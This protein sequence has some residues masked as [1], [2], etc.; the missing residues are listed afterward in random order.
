MSWNSFFSPDNLFFRFLSRAVDL[1]GLSMV[2]LLLSV[3]LV[4]LGPATAALYFAVVKCYRMGETRP[5]ALFWRSFRENLKTGALATLPVLAGGAVLFL[6][7][8]IMHYAA[9]Q[10]ATLLYGAYCAALFL[11]AGAACWLFP[12]LGRFSFSLGGLYVTAMKLTIR[13]LPS[14]VVVVLLVQQ[15]AAAALAHIWPLFFAPALA[16]LLVSLF[17]ERIF[18]RYMPPQP[19]SPPQE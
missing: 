8:D 15:L 4:T 6:G 14:T 19:P 18:P 2:W 5:Y 1:V 17:Y 10:G 7:W 16:A 9:A 3:P 11:P 13:H 12:L